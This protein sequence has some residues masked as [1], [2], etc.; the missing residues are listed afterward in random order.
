MRRLRSLIRKTEMP[1]LLRLMRHAAFCLLALLALGSAGAAAQTL[2]GTRWTYERIASVHFE[3]GGRIR[4]SRICNVIRASYRQLGGDRVEMSGGATRM[5]CSRPGIDVMGIE[6]RLLDGLRA[7]RRI[8]LR[9][10]RLELL[11]DA[12]AIVL[13]MTSAR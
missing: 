1:C 5:W 7:A 8:R 11:D 4:V 10:D 9:G 13:A 2:A 3:P 6:R 12:G